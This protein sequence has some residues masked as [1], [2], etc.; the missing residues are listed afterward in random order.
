MDPKT[1]AK[2]ELADLVIRHSGQL[3]QAAQLVA[4]KGILV[5]N[6]LHD[7]LE[8][9]DRVEDAGERRRQEVD[10]APD[11]VQ[12]VVTSGPRSGR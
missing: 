2:L 12:V 9:I 1:E 11:G 8:A 6:A 3:H 7:V 5:N 4:G 10:P